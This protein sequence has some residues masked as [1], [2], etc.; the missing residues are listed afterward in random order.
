V[1]KIHG[2]CEIGET[3]GPDIKLKHLLEFIKRHRNYIIFF[4]LFGVAL[5]SLFNSSLD[6]VINSQLFFPERQLAGTPELLGMDYENW[7]IEAIDG[8]K[9]HAWWIPAPKAKAV[10]LF[11]HGNAGNI[12]HRLDNLK[13][14]NGLGLSCLIIDYRGYGLSQ[15]SPN[16]KGFYLDAQAGHSAAAKLA[17]DNNL[18]LLVFGR[19]LGGA[20]AVAVGAEPGVRG[21]ILESTFTNLGGMAKAV[22][23][24]PGLD[25]LLASRFDSVGRIKNIKAPLLVFHGDADEIVPYRLGRELYEKAGGPKE[26]VT[27]K[28]AHHNDTVQVGGTAYLAKLTAFVDSITAE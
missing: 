11:F 3:E 9:L 13:L 23:H 24:L 28:G 22:F 7:A 8:I 17:K 14:L 27:L 10:L 19:S 1:S 5:V 25:S 6:A 20:A 18:P 12:S 4:L 21:V 15:G 2:P 26:F 16:E